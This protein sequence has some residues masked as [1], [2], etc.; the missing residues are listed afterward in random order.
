MLEIFAALMAEM[1]PLEAPEPQR[2]TR[3]PYSA[4]LQ[5]APINSGFGISGDFPDFAKFRSSQKNPRQGGRAPKAPP[6]GRAPKA[7]G[8]FQSH[9]KN[10]L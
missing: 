2:A 4:D 7:G 10:L 1:P 8:T 6:G 3:R 9:P 5:E